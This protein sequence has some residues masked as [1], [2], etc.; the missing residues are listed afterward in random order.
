MKFTPKTYSKTSFTVPKSSWEK[1]SQPNT[2]S[3]DI[4]SE[5]ALTS[6]ESSNPNIYSGDPLIF[7]KVSWVDASSHGGPNWV[8]LEDARE[9]AEAEYPL[10]N[11]VG[12]VLYYD[13]EPEGWISL[14]DTLGT[15][16]C[17]SVHKIPSCMIRNLEMLPC[18]NMM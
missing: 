2:Q 12:Y 16:E 6:E 14:T 13:P 4:T 8:D 18:K 17:S 5:E 15:D 11:T 7:A 1:P 3:I 9:F 10:M